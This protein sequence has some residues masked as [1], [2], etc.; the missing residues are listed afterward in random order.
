MKKS[1]VLHHCTPSS[2]SASICPPVFTFYL[3]YHVVTTVT[4]EAVGIFEVNYAVNALT[5]ILRVHVISSSD[6]G[7][8]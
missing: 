5:T 2:I 6:Q 7:Y 3:T 8:S 4:L 1:M